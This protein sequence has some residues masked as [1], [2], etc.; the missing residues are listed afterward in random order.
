M[1][2]PIVSA[3]ASLTTGVDQLPCWTVTGV[4]YPAY[5]TISCGPA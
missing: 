3:A 1:R 4:P 2:L 5:E